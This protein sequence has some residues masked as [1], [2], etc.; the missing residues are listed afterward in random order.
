MYDWVEPNRLG[1][2]F[3]INVG[4]TLPMRPETQYPVCIAGGGASPPEGCGHDRGYSALLELRSTI[5]SEEAEAK[6]RSYISRF[7]LGLFRET[8]EE[9]STKLM[10]WLEKF[11]PDAFELEEINPLHHGNSFAR[12]AG[13]GSEIRG[14]FQ[15]IQVKIP[16]AIVHLRAVLIPS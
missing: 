12:L 9:T 13:W 5:N 3:R 1:W 6:T 2:Q 11:D 14:V 15:I 4:K 16:I 8:Q 10:R 7:K